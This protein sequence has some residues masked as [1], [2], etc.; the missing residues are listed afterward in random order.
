MDYATQIDDKRKIG[1]D[2]LFR[3]QAGAR[4]IARRI[5]VAGDKKIDLTAS[6]PLYMRMVQAG[7]SK[8]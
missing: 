8:P 2:E 7:P 5:R 6:R 1:L 3:R 4:R